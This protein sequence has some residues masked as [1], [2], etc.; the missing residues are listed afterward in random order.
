MHSA[1]K[2]LAALLACVIAVCAGGCRI[3]LER[4]AAG[5]DAEPSQEEIREKS[6]FFTSMDKRF[7][8]MAPK[9]WYDGGYEEDYADSVLNLYSG[10]DAVFMSFYYYPKDTFSQ[11]ISLDDFARMVMRSFEGQDFHYQPEVYEDYV[12]D[13]RPARRDGIGVFYDD[14]PECWNFRLFSLEYPDAFVSIE[15]GVSNSDLPKAE[16]TIDII[17]RS[18]RRTEAGQSASNPVL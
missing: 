4:R 13:G 1:R 10:D 5:D 15:F 9:G 16:K 2:F 11:S 14:E 3:Q 6:D 12:I 7:I 18:I 17:A 8:V